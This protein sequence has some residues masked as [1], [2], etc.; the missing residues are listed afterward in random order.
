MNCPNLNSRPN[1][2]VQ[3]EH[4]IMCQAMK[5]TWTRNTLLSE[6][7]KKVLSGQDCLKVQQAAEG[8][9]VTVHYEGRLKTNGFKFDSS[10]D[11]GE[12]ITFELGK[13]QV[14]AGWEQGLL[15]SCSG[16]SISLDIPSQL[17]YG[18]KGAGEAIPAN[19]DLAF[20]MTLVAVKPKKVKIDVVD[21]KPCS[22]DQ[23]TRSNDVILFN[24]LGY[25]ENGALFHFLK[26]FYF[27]ASFQEQN[28]TRR[29]T[30]GA[31]L[32]KSLLEK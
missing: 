31:S 10:F 4:I 28:S 11:R 3:S 9:E 23:T 27:R 7:T 12:P 13:N 18:A 29:L 1:L 25:L 19:A 8:D 30:K 20:N 6:L 22:P 16:Q 17:G 26:G 21:P 2:S 15:G 14:I 5:V 32:W 24:Y